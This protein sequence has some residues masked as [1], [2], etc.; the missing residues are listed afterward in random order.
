MDITVLHVDDC[1]NLAPLMEQLEEML[2]G[3]D[4]VALVIN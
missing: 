4:D 1:P 3:R 2:V